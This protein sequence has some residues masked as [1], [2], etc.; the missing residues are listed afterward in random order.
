MSSFTHVI[1]YIKTHILRA[2][3]LLIVVA[4]AFWGIERIN[5]TLFDAL[6]PIVLTLL[7]YGSWQAFLILGIA[8]LIG[9]LL[10][11]PFFPFVFTAGMLFG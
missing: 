11:I 1:T 2:F 9:T 3:V 4:V 7:E 6:P 10:C 5:A 8:M